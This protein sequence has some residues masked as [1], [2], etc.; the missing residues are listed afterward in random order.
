MKLT[1]PSVLAALSLAAGSV[2]AALTVTEPRT[3]H[4]CE[5][6]SSLLVRAARQ[7]HCGSYAVAADL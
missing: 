2:S 1:I 3:D 5:F 7:G 4:W 6:L